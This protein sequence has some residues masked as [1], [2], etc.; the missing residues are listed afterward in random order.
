MRNLIAVLGA[1]LLLALLSVACKGKEAP[2]PNPEPTPAPT[3]VVEPEP[4]AVAGATCVVG[5][6]PAGNPPVCKDAAGAQVP[7]P[8]DLSGLPE[9]AK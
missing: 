4:T 8:V 2:P 6:M 3:I 1:L 9:C 7:C 5:D